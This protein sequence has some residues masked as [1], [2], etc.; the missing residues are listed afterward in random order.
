MR[1]PRITARLWIGLFVS[2]SV[3][4]LARGQDS[5]YQAEALSLPVPAS[6]AKQ[7]GGLLDAQ[8]Y[9]VS[10]VGGAAYAEIWLR[11]SIPASARPTGPKGNVLYPVLSSGEILGVLQYNSEGGDYR[12]QPIAKG[13]Y[14]LRYGLQ[15][16]NG[17]HLGV[18]PY[19]DYALLL[20][21]E[22]DQST[23]ALEREKLEEE[24]AKAAGTSHPAILMMMP[25]PEG[26]KLGTMHHDEAKST[27]G[28]ILPLTL[29]VEGA[30]EPITLPVQL[31]VVGK[32]AD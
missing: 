10:Q 16:V 30:S 24:S 19:R 15:P 4:D 29:K 7:V 5:Q 31:I 14:T 2:L 21:S 25:V 27:W 26:G 9:K 32:A 3:G 20:P 8:G 18:S 13:V 23:Q 12:D 28:V 6:L 17:D 1:L 11:K 22:I